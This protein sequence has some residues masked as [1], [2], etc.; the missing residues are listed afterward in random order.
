MTGLP[1][2]VDVLVVGGGQAGL[3]AA[4]WLTREPGLRVLVVER[5]EVA[6]ADVAAVIAATLAD[7]STIARTIRFGMGDVPIGDALSE[8]RPAGEP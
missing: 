4:Y 8:E 5:A 7:D 1:Q 2:D 6:R 3:G